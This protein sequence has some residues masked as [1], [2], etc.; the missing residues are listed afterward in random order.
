MEELSNN[1]SNY[2]S[3]SSSSSNIIRR[4]SSSVGRKDEVRAAQR[5]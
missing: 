5:K 4:Q 2:S 1:L 3:S